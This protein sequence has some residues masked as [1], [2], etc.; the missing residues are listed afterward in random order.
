VVSGNE[1]LRGVIPL[2]A[3]DLDVDPR[4]QALV[5]NPKHP[6]YPVALAV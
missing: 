1:P 6:N 4:Q 5:V 2:E 3:M